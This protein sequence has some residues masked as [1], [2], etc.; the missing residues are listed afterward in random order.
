MNF[1][2]RYFDPFLDQ[3]ADGLQWLSKQLR[4]A[5]QVYL[6]EGLN[7]DWIGADGQPISARQTF[8]GSD[9]TV[10]LDERNFL[11][12]DLTLPVAAKAY[13]DD[14]VA[15]RI[16]LISP[17]TRQNAVF[18]ASL[19]SETSTAITVTVAA[20]SKDSINRK[21]DRLRRLQPQSLTILVTARAK[22]SPTVITLPIAGIKANS[23]AKRRALISRGFYSSLVAMGILIAACF[24]ARLYLDAEHVQIESQI[25]ALRATLNPQSLDDAVVRDPVLRMTVAKK[26]RWPMV[27]LLAQL[28][29]TLPDDTYLNS[30]DL[31]SGEMRIEGQSKNVAELPRILGQNTAFSEIAFTAP[32]IKREGRGGDLFELGF[33]VSDRGSSVP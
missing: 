16:D 2:A 31:I 29:A 8:E 19:V 12:V 32:T 4:P 26:S 13:I 14:I 11:I 1:L 30:I 18:G 17:W 24:V 27:D 25:H 33:K 23:P 22:T 21:I 7:G 3:A 15:S 28:A 9:L 20:S 10:V 6:K 5:H